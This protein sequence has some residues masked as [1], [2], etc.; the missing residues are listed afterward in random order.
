MTAKTMPQMPALPETLHPVLA[1][2]GFGLPLGSCFQT[3]WHIF[4][5]D[6]ST[7]KFLSFDSEFEFE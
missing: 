1:E 7:G 5:N 2:T 6:R 3:A 4:W